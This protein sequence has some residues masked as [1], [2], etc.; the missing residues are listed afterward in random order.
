M[1]RY[2]LP[3]YIKRWVE[4]SP[5]PTISVFGATR[6][7]L[8]LTLHDLQKLPLAA[9]QADFHCVT[10]WSKPDLHWQGWAFQEIWRTYLRE[11]A[12]V[13]VSHI[14][15]SASDGF[16]ATIPLAEL[17][18]E[19]VLLAT[20]LNHAP[21]TVKHGAPVRLVTPQLYGYKNLKHVY[22]MELLTEPKPSG[23]TSRL[24]IHPRGRVDLE[25]RSSAGF[26]LFWRTL[27]RWQLPNFLREAVRWQE[28]R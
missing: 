23:V 4:L 24:L 27:Y 16:A 9:V 6:I 15:F 14:R 22:R 1:P 28:R 12:E 21:L 10:T 8:I 3:K 19:D 5:H 11:F 18:R 7:P 13:E 20:Q 2:G 17:L 25:E 26:P